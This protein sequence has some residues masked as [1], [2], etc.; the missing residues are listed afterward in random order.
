MT[1]TA[2]KQDAASAERRVDDELPDQQLVQ[3]RLSRQTL[4]ALLRLQA[5]TGIN[6]RTH[7]IASCIREAS[8]IRESLREDGGKLCIIRK[9]QDPRSGHIYEMKE[10]IAITF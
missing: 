4:K 8:L 5:M 1:K 6:N 2:K 10:L 9:E 3:V 7:L